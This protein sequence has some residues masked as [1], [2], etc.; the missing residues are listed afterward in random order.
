[1]VQL[2]YS[3]ILGFQFIPPPLLSLLEVHMF[4]RY[5]EKH[6]LTDGVH[7]CL[8]FCL[9][10]KIKHTIFPGEH[11]STPL[12]Q[13]CVENPMGKGAWKAAVHGVA[14]GQT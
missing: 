4:V 5:L 6:G 10:N 9:E 3:P 11:H 14:E 12:Q 2:I 1:M 13:P 8:Y 7:L